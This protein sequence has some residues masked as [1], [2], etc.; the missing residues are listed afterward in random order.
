MDEFFDA[1]R[2][3]ETSKVATLLRA[4]PDLAWA[5]GEHGKT[6]L[7]WAAEADQVE[8]ARVLLDAGADVEAQTS[9][10]ATQAS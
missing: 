7:H 8:V 3:G 4:H 1:V 10:G 6:G 9:W 2:R 5:R